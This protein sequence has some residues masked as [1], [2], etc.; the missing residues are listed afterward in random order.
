M[1]SDP[2]T[3]IRA[4]HYRAKL[5]HRRRLR[6]DPAYR[7]DWFKDHAKNLVAIGAVAGLSVG[8]HEAIKPVLSNPEPDKGPVGKIGGH[9]Q[10]QGSEMPSSAQLKQ[11]THEHGISLNQK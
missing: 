7:A 8:I 11:F 4:E 3:R 10:R 1:E 2:Y 9:E 6:E 5:R